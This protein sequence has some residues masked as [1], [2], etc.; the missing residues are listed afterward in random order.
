MNF[1]KWLT[2]LYKNQ[3]QNYFPINA[4]RYFKKFKYEFFYHFDTHTEKDL[5]G[6]DTSLFMGSWVVGHTKES[7]LKFV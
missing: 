6:D 5:P 1:N 4:I 2:K 7:F 3:E